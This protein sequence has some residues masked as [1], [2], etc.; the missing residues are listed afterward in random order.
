MG[1]MV[2]GKAMSD[3]GGIEPP[4]QR[5]ITNGSLLI[6]DTSVSGLCPNV[7]TARLLTMTVLMRLAG[8]GCQSPVLSR[9]VEI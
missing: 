2:I 1:L 6:P 8:D 9:A 3:F 5:M 4:S 7:W